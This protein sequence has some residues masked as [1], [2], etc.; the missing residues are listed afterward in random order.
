MNRKATVIAVP[1]AAVVA[2]LGIVLGAV[3]S[4]LYVGLVGA[5]IAGEIIPPDV[6]GFAARLDPAPA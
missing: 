5:M 2:G 6:D 3:L 1:L 4:P